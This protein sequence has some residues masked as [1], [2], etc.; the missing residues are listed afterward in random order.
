MPAKHHHAREDG[1]EELERERTPDPI[2]LTG[3][4]YRALV[5]F[6]LPTFLC[7]VIGGCLGYACWKLI[8]WNREDAKAFVQ[9]I[10]RNTTAINELKESEKTLLE[11]QNNTLK[12]IDDKFAA[13][14]AED[15]R[16]HR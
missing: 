10:E 15:E 12:A 9:V 11:K 7:L 4:A 14:L 6:G 8:I 1:D 3:F 16:R 13:H 2:N 5:R